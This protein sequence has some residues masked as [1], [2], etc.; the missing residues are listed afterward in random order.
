MESMPNGKYSTL[1]LHSI[2]NFAMPC[3]VTVRISSSFFT[4]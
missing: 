3:R 1:S 2:H 4:T